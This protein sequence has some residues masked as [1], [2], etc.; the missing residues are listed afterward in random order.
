MYKMYAADARARLNLGIRR[1]LAPLMDNDTDRI[2]LMN[3]MLLSMPGSPIIYYGDEIGMGDNFFLGDRNGV[4]TPMQWSPD[5]NAGFSRADPQRLY[6]PPIMDPIYGY[7]VRERR[8]ADP[9]PFFAA[10]LDEAHASDAQAVAGIRPRHDEVHPARQS[11]G[12]RVSARVRRRHD[13]VRG[14][15]RLVRRSRSSWI[16]RTYK[17]TVPIEMLGRTPFPPVGDLPYML[18]LP[19]YAFYW[20]KL[21]REVEA[22]SWHEETAGARRSASARPHGRMEQ[23]PARARA[24]LARERGDQTAHRGRAARDAGIR[25]GPSAGSRPRARPFSGWRSRMAVSGPVRRE[26]GCW[27]SSRSRRPPVPRRRLIPRSP[28]LKRRAL[29]DISFHCRSA[30]TMPTKRA[31]RSFSRESSH[32]CAGKP[33]WA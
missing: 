25:R 26:A 19:G 27:R 30:T 10:E 4:R 13:S 20:F 31:C 14:E 28:R 1:R 3:S 23:L 32:A 9:R 15:P 22:P 18:T 33:R 2:K 24:V 7:E 17:G 6:L 8:S 11:Q 12:A 5:R 29:H 16:C 21:S